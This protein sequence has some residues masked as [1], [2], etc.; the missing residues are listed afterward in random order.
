VAIEIK[1][2]QLRLSLCGIAPAI[3]RDFTVFHLAILVHISDIE[4]TTTSAVCRY[5]TQRPQLIFH[6]S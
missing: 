4:T 6:V 3:A 1:F 5:V 2:H